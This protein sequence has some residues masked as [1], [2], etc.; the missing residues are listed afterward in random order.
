V[1]SGATHWAMRFTVVA[2]S[3]CIRSGTEEPRYTFLDRW[4][5]ASMVHVSR[6]KPR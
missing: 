4:R 3:L 5:S 6:P 2:M 1:L